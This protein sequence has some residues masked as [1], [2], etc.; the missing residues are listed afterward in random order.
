GLVWWY[1]L[2]VV[3]YAGLIFF[4]S[5]L[6]HPEVYT[7]SFLYEIGDKSLHAFE[8]GVLGIL[9]YRAFHHAAGAWAARYA[10]LLAIVSSVGYALTDEVHQAFVPLREPEVWDLVA[11]SIG[12]SV[13]AFGW[14]WT[15]EP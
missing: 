10:L 1:W 7:P 12:A 8:Y 4:L 3:A 15:V 6:S 5:S 13:A 2:P 9:C 11:D 14:R